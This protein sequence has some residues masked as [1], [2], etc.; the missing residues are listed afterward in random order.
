MIR[1]I[2]IVSAITLIGC[3]STDEQGTST[4]TVQTNKQEMVCEQRATT[5]SNLKK[6]RCMSKKLAEEVRKVNQ[7]NMRTLKRN[8]QIATKNKN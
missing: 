6:K 3:H 8:Q 2:T 1:I 5:G 7:E 4:Q